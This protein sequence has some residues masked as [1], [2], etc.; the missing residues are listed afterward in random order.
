MASGGQE[1]FK[2]LK[3]FLNF[4]GRIAKLTY[5]QVDETYADW[6]Y[7]YFA[8]Y[9]K[10]LLFNVHVPWP[11]HYT[12]IVTSPSRIKFGRKTSPGSGP[13]Q[14]IQ[15]T[16]GID[17]GDNVQF[18]PG[19]QLISANHDPDDFDLPIATRPL[20]IGSNVWIGGNAIVL[21]GVSIGDNVIVGAGAVVTKDLPSNSVAVGNPA[22]VIRQKGPYKGK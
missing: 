4:F 19:V 3:W 5:R 12:S 8:F 6:K 20:R 18:G 13:C 10:I 7:V 22:R 15:G 16:N 17:I 14:Y 21:P 9:Q 2:L 11:V 1:D